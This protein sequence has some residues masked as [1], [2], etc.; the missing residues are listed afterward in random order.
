VILIEFPR[1]EMLSA[2]ISACDADEQDRDLFI[3]AWRQ[4][5]MRT[6]R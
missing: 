5:K 2:V 1:L 4:V 3:S 6:I